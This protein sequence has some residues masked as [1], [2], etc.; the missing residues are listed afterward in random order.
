MAKKAGRAGFSRRDFFKLTGLGSAVTLG[1]DGCSLIPSLTPTFSATL[2]RREDLVSLKF[3]FVNLTLSTASDG[4]QQ[5]VPNGAGASYIIVNFQPQHIF[6]E[7]L[8]EN[9]TPSPPLEKPVDARIAGGSRIVL[10]VPAD[11]TPIPYT[12]EGLLAALGA[13]EMSLAP[14]ALPPPR[15]RVMPVITPVITPAM[16]ATNTIDAST[17]TRTQKLIVAGQQLAASAGVDPSVLSTANAGDVTTAA[18]QVFPL[19][20]GVTAA[21]VASQIDVILQRPPRPRAPFNGETAIELPYRLEISPNSSGGWAHNDDAAKG[22]KLGRYEL[23]HTRLGVRDA[24]TGAVSEAPS[25]LKTFR[26]IWTRDPGFDPATQTTTPALNA[27]DAADNPFAHASLTASWRGQIVQQTSNF[28]DFGSYTPKAVDSNLL[29]LSSLG[30][31]LDSHAD[32]G[33]N[34]P[35][36]VIDWDHK[37]SLGRDYF[38]KIVEKGRLYPWGHFAVKI[39]IT[40]RKFRQPDENTA[41]LWQRTFIIVT[42]PV[43]TYPAGWRR[44]PWTSIAVKTLVTPN[45]Y[46]PTP[47]PSPSLSIKTD[48]TTP[49]RFKLE[50]VDLEGNTQ[51]FDGVAVWTPMSGSTLFDVPNAASLYTSDF[52]DSRRSSFDGQRVAYSRN[53]KPDDTTYETASIVFEGTQQSSPPP[54]V[55]FPAAGIPYLPHVDEASLNVEAIRHLVGQGAPTAFQYHDT[56][57]AQGFP[58]IVPGSTNPGELVMK[59]K[60]L[61][62]PLGLDFTKKSDSSGGF[63]APSLDIKGLSRLTGPVAGDLDKIANNNFDPS[64][65]LDSV[66]ALVF[67]VIPLKDIISAVGGLASAPSFVTQTVNAVTGF[68]QDILDLKARIQKAIDTLTAAGK[69]IDSALTNLQNK[70]DAVVTAVNALFSASDVDTAISDAQTLIGDL[71]SLL[72]AFLGVVDALPQPPLLLSVKTDLKKRAKSVKDVLDEVKNVL[73]AFATGLDL[74]KNLTVKLDW[75]ADVQSDPFGFFVPNKVSKGD[76]ADGGFILAVEARGKK[77]GDKPAGVDITAGLENFDVNVFGTSA[78]L[79]TIPFEHLLFVVESGKKPDIDVKFRGDVGFDGVLAFVKTLAELVPGGGFSDPPSLEVSAEGIKASFSVAIPSIAVGVFSIENISLGGGFEVPFIGNPLS[80]SF[81]F[82]T[83]D[84]PFVLTVM[85]I[86]GGGYFGIKLSPHGLLLLEAALEARAELSLDF[87]IAS[88]SVSIAVGVY[89]RLEESGGKQDGQLTGYIKI[90]GQVDVLGIITASITLELDL[91]YEFASGKLIGKATLTI[92][93]SIAFF[94]FS[95]SA[96]VERKLAGSGSDP[97]FADQMSDYLLPDGSTAHPW[98]DY[99][100]SFLLAA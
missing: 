61:S 22:L 17:V 27:L 11:K 59:L 58:D 12:T 66:N 41:Y 23:W 40:E 70:V 28:R 7:A 96:S 63:L 20:P 86:G 42:E 35:L 73:K 88:G 38:V 6:E 21:Q 78:T 84:E 81:N 2:V 47:M 53:K 46:I 99:L 8:L 77:V 98:A 30:G 24:N 65:F 74:A 72:D 92:E 43:R 80:V 94:S 82:C 52:G 79:V 31:W 91:I 33:V 44:F 55:T 14:N 48:A 10:I 97:T 37:A 71:E 36:T 54:G 32:F 85:C 83:R 16:L 95:V 89:F 69:A 68:I 93:V 9:P 76:A 60:D 19:P 3:D 15:P 1:I 56:Y 67:G 39:T 29:M 62:S 64:S 5:I 100:G 13:L 18:A 90:H 57:L 4:S 45:I 51:K 34:A 75:R 49:F 50:G 87:G 25:Y 26:A